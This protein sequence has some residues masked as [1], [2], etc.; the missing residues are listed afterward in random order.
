MSEKLARFVMPDN[1]W[2][3]VGDGPYASL[4]ARADFF[5]PVAPTKYMA[6]EVHPKRRLKHLLSKDVRTC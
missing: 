2:I 3:F 5:V 1:A 4:D 6:D